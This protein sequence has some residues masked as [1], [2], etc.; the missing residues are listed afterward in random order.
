V[1]TNSTRPVSIVIS[2]DQFRSQKTGEILAILLS[3]SASRDSIVK[4]RGAVKLRAELPVADPDVKSFFT[5][6]NAVW[7]LWTHFIE[8]RES[9]D[10]VTSALCGDSKKKKAA[11]VA[12]CEQAVGLWL[13]AYDLD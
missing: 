9:L 13:L 6:L 8:D 12:G 5:T 10:F 11:F 1:I 3:L 4:Y 2:A 7:P